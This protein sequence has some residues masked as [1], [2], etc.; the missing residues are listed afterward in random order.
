MKK[1]KLLVVDDEVG[2][3]E[4]IE[5]LLAD[6]FDE[7]LTAES[8]EDALVLYEK[9]KSEI[10]VIVSDLA[11]PNT[12][13]IDFLSQIRKQDQEISF[14]LFSGFGETSEIMLSVRYGAY[15]FVEKPEYDQLKTS[16]IESLATVKTK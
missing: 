14:I 7:V 9:N 11:M 8:A 10:K 13:G 5:V 6:H 16:V 1:S 15:D 2:I 4:A 3:L 12:G